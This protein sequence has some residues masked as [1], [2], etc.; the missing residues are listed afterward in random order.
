MVR[1]RE[2]QK[3]TP[4][5]AVSSASRCLKSFPSAAWVELGCREDAVSSTRKGN[6][7]ALML[8]LGSC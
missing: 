6:C 2:L 5:I 1:E 8:R 3:V 4:E 7:R